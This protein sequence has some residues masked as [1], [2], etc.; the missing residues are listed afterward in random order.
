MRAQVLVCLVVCLFVVS[1]PGFT[2][3]RVN[4][5]L[6][7]KDVEQLTTQYATSTREAAAARDS[8]KYD[9]MIEAYGNCL[10]IAKQLCEP[11]DDSLLAFCK[12]NLAV[13]RQLEFPISDN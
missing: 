13:R 10:S 2:Q 1:D 11:G 12:N 3:D 7:K 8:G 5:A 4:K 9:K 6:S